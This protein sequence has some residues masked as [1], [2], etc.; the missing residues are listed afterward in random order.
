MS[1]VAVDGSDGAP[2]FWASGLG[3]QAARQAY[4]NCLDYVNV[5]DGNPAYIHV[6][7][8]Y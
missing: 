6:E 5:A 1:C 8:G 7:C 2:E 4:Q 3:D